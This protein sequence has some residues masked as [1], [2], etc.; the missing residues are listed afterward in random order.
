MTIRQPLKTPSPA[1]SGSE[2]LARLEPYARN[3]LLAI[4]V[5]AALLLVGQ[6]TGASAVASVLQR[7][8]MEAWASRSPAHAAAMARYLACDKSEQESTKKAC[9][10]LVA[11][12]GLAAELEQVTATPQAA[13]EALPRPLRWFLN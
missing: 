11:A 2:R 10:D 8:R 6:Y 7:D 3:T 13:W 12:D 4:I 1:P 9:V 5:A